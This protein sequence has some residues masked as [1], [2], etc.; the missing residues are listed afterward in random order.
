MDWWVFLF[1]LELYLNLTCLPCCLLTRSARLRGAGGKKR[2]R[3]RDTEIETDRQRGAYVLNGWPP[4]RCICK[5]IACLWNSYLHVTYA[6]VRGICK[7]YGINWNWWMI[8]VS[9]RSIPEIFDVCTFQP[10]VN[11]GSSSGSFQAHDRLVEKPRDASKFNIFTRKP[12]TSKSVPAEPVWL[13]N[14]DKPESNQ[15]HL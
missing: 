9:I 7:K 5:N 2:H 15:K 3:D 12:R 4:T 10:S 13:I 14:F 11:C 1:A 8:A 6:G